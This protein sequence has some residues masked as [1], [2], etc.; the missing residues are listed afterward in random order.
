MYIH[1]SYTYIYYILCIHTWAKSAWQIL[2]N[3]KGLHNQP[4]AAWVLG[5]VK[6]SFLTMGMSGA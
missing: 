4:H 6:G 2:A 3:A 5:G 1:C